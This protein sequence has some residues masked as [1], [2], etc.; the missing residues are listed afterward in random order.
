MHEYLRLTDYANRQKNESL[1][2]NAEINAIMIADLVFSYLK[3]S[4][5]KSI[6]LL[7]LTHNIDNLDSKRLIKPS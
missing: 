1:F 7:G 3:A 4:I 6:V 5:E 2:I